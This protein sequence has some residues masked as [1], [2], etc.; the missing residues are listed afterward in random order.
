MKLQSWVVGIVVATAL[1]CAPFVASAQSSLAVADAA[2]FLGNWAVNMDTPQG[3]FTMNLNL[4]D[5]AGKVAGE[6]SADQLP[7]QEI[8]DITK[9]GENLVLKYASDFQGQA[10]NV[11][12]TMSVDG[13][14]GKV[15][16]DAADGQF[17]MDGAATK[18]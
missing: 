14:K 13:A 2:K 15:T 16:F 5:K 8:T 18:K 9:A 12:I 4:T 11:K 6:I 17:V 3:A 7:T 10:F 1:V